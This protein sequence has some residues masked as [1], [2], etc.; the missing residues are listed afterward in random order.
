MV[1]VLGGA[2]LGCKSA[3]DER[4]RLGRVQSGNWLA[5]CHGGQ[6]QQQEEAE[7]AAHM[8]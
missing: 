8:V 4:L 2:Q 7:E 6:G 3:I 1:C 5:L